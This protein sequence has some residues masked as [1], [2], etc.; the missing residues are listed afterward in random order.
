MGT[1]QRILLCSS[2]L[3]LTQSGKSSQNQILTTFAYTGLQIHTIDCLSLKEGRKQLLCQ[4]DFRAC[5]QPAPAFLEFSGSFLDLRCSS[6]AQQCQ[7]TC[8]FTLPVPD[9]PLPPCLA[10]TSLWAVRIAC[11]KLCQSGKVKKHPES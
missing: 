9:H 3:P 11:L 10:V 8:C 6:N 4:H 1:F 5:I 2:V 7:H